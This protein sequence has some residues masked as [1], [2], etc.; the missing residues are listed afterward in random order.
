AN[1]KAPR[2]RPGLI[3]RLVVEAFH[4]AGALRLELGKLSERRS[5]LDEVSLLIPGIAPPGF[6][7]L[8]RGIAVTLPPAQ[9]SNKFGH[10]LGDEMA[11]K[12]PAFKPLAGGGD[13]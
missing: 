1:Q 9:T 8:G 5:S 2:V 7:A 6:L 12:T 11:L 3:T 4:R 10:S 13:V